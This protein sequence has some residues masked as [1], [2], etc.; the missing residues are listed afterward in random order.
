MARVAPSCET[1]PLA[2]MVTSVP[3]GSAA[4]GVNVSFLASVDSA[5]DPVTGVAPTVA[6]KL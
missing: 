3:P 2:V 1:T 6:V 5:I 4:A